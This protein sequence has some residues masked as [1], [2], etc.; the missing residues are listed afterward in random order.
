[1]PKTILVVDDEKDIV[2]MV[3]YNLE[4]EGYEVL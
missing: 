3:K 1:M 4:R 2:E